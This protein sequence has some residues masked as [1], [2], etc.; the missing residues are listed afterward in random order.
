MAAIY[1]EA[2]ATT[3]ATF[4]TEPRPEVAQI[5]WLREHSDPF[6]AIVAESEGRVVG[7]ASLSRWSERRA[8][9]ATAEVSLYVL[10]TQRGR[11]IG[12]RLLEHL[13]EQGRQG[14][15]HTLLAR[16]ADGNHVSIHLHEALGFCPVGI[17]REVGWKFGRR[18]D[19]QLLQKIYDDSAPAAPVASETPVRRRPTCTEFQS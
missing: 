5:L 17:M 18:I 14:Q 12:R 6:V 16:V 13:V 4:D 3:V 11:G 1:N 9:S 2:V 19:V 8:Y 15:L 10:S 7:W